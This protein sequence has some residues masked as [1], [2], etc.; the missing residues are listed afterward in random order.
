VTKQLLEKYTEMTKDTTS[1]LEEQIAELSTKL[2]ILQ[3]GQTGPSSDCLGTQ[4]RNEPTIAKQALDQKASLEQC[5]TIC[6]QLLVHIE[7]VKLSISE[8]AASAMGTTSVHDIVEGADILAPRLTVDALNICTNSINATAQQLR[9]L[10]EG[11]KSTNEFDEA[12]IMHQLDS[13]RQSLYIVGKAQQ[14][15]INAFENIALGDGSFQTVV[16]TM[17]DLIKANG[18]TVGSRSGNIMGQMSDETL[19]KIACNFGPTISEKSSPVENRTMFEE[20][21]G[22]GRTMHRGRQ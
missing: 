1:D 15:R 22:F 12:R 11:N 16:S 2:M 3:S 10:R 5:L 20:K 7:K 13:V 4:S 18:L 21:H 9:D 6:H 19:Q 8:E 14:H 17:G